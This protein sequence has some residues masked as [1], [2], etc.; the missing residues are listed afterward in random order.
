MLVGVGVAVVVDV[1]VAVSVGVNVGVAVSVLVL[2]PPPVVAETISSSLIALVPLELS[3]A[4]RLAN[5]QNEKGRFSRGFARFATYF[6]WQT[7]CGL[8]PVTRV[9][10]TLPRGAHAKLAKTCCKIEHSSRRKGPAEGGIA[11]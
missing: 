7:Y 5:W 1:A 10:A 8:A 11:A 6:E 3:L 4:R 9:C 2:W